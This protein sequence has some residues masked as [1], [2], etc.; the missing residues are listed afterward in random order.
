MKETLK[1]PMLDNVCLLYWQVEGLQNILNY[2]PSEH[3]WYSEK[4]FVYWC[5]FINYVLFH[6]KIVFAHK[7]ICVLFYTK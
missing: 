5:L 6:T 7:L 4:V 1:Y 2:F 3:K